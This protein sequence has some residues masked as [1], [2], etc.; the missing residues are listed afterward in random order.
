M[1]TLFASDDVKENLLCKNPLVKATWLVDKYADH[2][3]IVD[4]F[5]HLL[6]D[7]L[8]FNDDWLYVFPQMNLPLKY[9][10][11]KAKTMAKADF[12]VMHV[13]SFFRMAVVEDKRQQD[14]MVNSEPQLIAEAIA[15]SQA[16]SESKSRKRPVSEI[17]TATS[18]SSDGTEDRD[19]L[20]GVRVNGLRFYFY[21][22]PVSDAILKAMKTKRVA[23][24]ETDVLCLY[25]GGNYFDWGVAE[26]RS[27]IIKVLD[28]VRSYMS[29]R[30]D[31]VQRR[32]SFSQAGKAHTS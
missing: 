16:N 31:G 19:V 21:V 14:H 29:T 1:Q 30:G 3:S 2:E 27:V 18:S 15:L 5:V 17:N 24:S 26:R 23:E 10:E 13:L 20:F 9:G 22:I 25:D 32:S 4:S 12:V 7:R 28:K 8:G 6:L 11:I